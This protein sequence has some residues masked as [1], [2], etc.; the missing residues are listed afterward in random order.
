MNTQMTDGLVQT[1]VTAVD[2]R[3]REHLEA[4]WVSAVPQAPHQTHV[5]AA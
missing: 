5:H 4:R 3:G 1:W 2:A